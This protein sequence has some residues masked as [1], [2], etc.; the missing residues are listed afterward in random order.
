MLRERE[1]RMRERKLSH[2]N[3]YFLNSFRRSKCEDNDLRM[4]TVVQKETEREK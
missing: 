4:D 3:L 1:R 2:S